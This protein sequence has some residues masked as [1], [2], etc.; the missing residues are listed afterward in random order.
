MN[1]PRD[2]V[3][4]ERHWKQLGDRSDSVR[5][6]GRWNELSDTSDVKDLSSPLICTTIFRT[7]LENFE[8][9]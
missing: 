2:L 3:R 7:F 1:V 9:V 6:D 5:K 4:N 8:I